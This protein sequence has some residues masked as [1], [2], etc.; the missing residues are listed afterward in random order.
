MQ[1]YNNEQTVVHFINGTTHS[2]PGLRT[3]NVFNPSRG[4]VARQVELADVA[5]VNK[6]VE[7]AKAALPAWANKPPLQRARIMNNFLA[8]MNQ[9]RDE[10]AAIITAE[11]GKV[12]T[13]AQGEV[14]RG[15]DIIEFACGIPQLLKGDYTEQVSTNIDNWTLRQPVGVVARVSPLSTFRAWCL[16]GCSLWP[17]PAATPLY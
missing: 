13:D 10:L 11:H 16:A 14:S 3:A 5:T 15:I 8:L 17:L 9:H 6:A 7:A 2:N 1:P 4:S 12:F